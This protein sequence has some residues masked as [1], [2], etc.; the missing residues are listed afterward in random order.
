LSAVISRAS[1][2]RAVARDQGIG[3]AAACRPRHEAQVLED[4]V[5]SAGPFPCTA[6]PGRSPAGPGSPDS[7]TSEAGR[8]PAMVTRRR[9][10]A[11]QRKGRRGRALASRARSR[12]GCAP[13]RAAAVGSKG[14]DPD[15]DVQ[16]FTGAP[17]R[18][19]SLEASPLQVTPGTGLRC[20]GNGEASPGPGPAETLAQPWTISS[21]SVVLSSRP[22]AWPQGRFR[23]GD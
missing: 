15:V 9:N 11:S 14:V 4:R 5:G 8:R 13:W 23:Q 6:P 17:V 12:A 7:C 10:E 16:R 20:R 18:H 21:V 19:A 1:W 22:V 2:R 3:H